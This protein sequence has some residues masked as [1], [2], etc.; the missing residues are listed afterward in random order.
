MG[1]VGSRLAD[2]VAK[3]GKL[4]ENMIVMTTEFIVL[5]FMTLI[6]CDYNV[7]G[8]GSNDGQMCLT[9]IS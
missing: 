2:D 8:G 7:R 9:L 3:H 4:W 1:S 5:A 6:F